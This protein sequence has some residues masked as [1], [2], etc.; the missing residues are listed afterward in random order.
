MTE[1]NLPTEGVISEWVEASTTEEMVQIP[2]SKFDKMVRQNIDYHSLKTKQRMTASAEQTN[3]SEYDPEQMKIINDLVDEKLNEK[4]KENQDPYNDKELTTFINKNPDAIDV[5]WDV[6]GLRKQFP[7]LSYSQLY[8][9]VWG[10]AQEHKMPQIKTTPPITAPKKDNKEPTKEEINKAWK[11]WQN[12]AF[13]N[14]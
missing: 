12:K 11:D 13:G 1:E 7:N 4:M 9:M 3:N 8:N 2:K 10:N 6:M 5:L 14:R